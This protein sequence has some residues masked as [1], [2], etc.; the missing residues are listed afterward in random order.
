ME[1]FLQLYQ[2]DIVG[3]LHG[4]DRILFRGTLRSICFPGGLEKFLVNQRV[5]LKDFGPYAQKLTKTVKHHAKQFAKGLGRPYV[6]LNSPSADK[7]AEIRKILAEQPI[8]EGLIAVLA[9][10]EQCHSFDVRTNP[11]NQRLELYSRPRQCTHFYFYYLDRD[12]G[13]MHIR[14]QSWLP[15]PIQVCLNGREYLARQLDQQGI[16]YEKR[17]NCFTRIDNLPRA[18]ELLDRLQTQSWVGFLNR[19]ARRVL[20]LLSKRSR[21]QLRSYYWTTRQD[22]FA[23]DILFKDAATL[24]AIYPALVD[25]ALQH[26]SCKDVLRFLGRRVNSRFQGEVTTD[27]DERIEG[28]R[29]KH[30]VEENSIKMYD[31]QGCILRIETTINCP[32]RFRVRRFTTRNGH[33]QRRWAALRKGVV[34]LPRRAQLARAANERYLEALAGV[35][36]PA[37]VHRILD[38]VSRPKLHQGRHYRGLRPLSPEEARLYRLL[39]DGRF[40]LQGVRNR[41]LREVLG[42]RPSQDAR[43]RRQRSGRATRWLRLFR[44]HGILRKVPSTRYYRLSEKGIEILTTALRVRNCNIQGLAS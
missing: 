44:A 12:F 26:F 23:T 21:P 27:L 10:V 24:Q 29:L 40:A 13:L 22:E 36:R 38:P 18:Q 32:T 41:D 34:D 33:R 11:H 15:F 20:P 39:L 28:L 16:G 2:A 25:H 4:F 1:R 7:N 3:V 6:Y 19:L 9:C 5:L 37:P 42:G 35:T 30:R 43:A 31:K 14:L 17:D 8:T